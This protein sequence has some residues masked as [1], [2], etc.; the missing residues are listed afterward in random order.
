MEGACVFSVI[1]HCLRPRCHFDFATH[2]SPGSIVMELRICIDVDNIA[3]AIAFYTQG[4]EL[5]VGRRFDSGFAELPGAG[6]PIDL[7]LNAARTH[8]NAGY[9]ETRHYQRHWTPVHLDFVV[10]DVNAAVA[11][12]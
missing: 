5:R 10:D 8:P 4:L 9:Q 11:P 3:R 6:S 1:T 12:D 2:Y 7:L